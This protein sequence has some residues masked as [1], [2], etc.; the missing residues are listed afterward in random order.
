MKTIHKGVTTR[1]ILN[2][3]LFIAGLFAIAVGVIVYNGYRNYRRLQLEG[4]PA[5]AYIKHAVMN[6]D[7]PAC[8]V[9]YEFN[10]RIY[11]GEV[12]GYR[13]FDADHVLPIRID[14]RDPCNFILE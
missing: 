9:E 11:G 14:P 12:T 2:G 6:W 7:V 3:G 5:K 1:P 13:I 10:H 8:Y 4:V